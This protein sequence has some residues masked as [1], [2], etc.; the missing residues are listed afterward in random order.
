V[1]DTFRAKEPRTALE[2][3][4]AAQRNELKTH[5][6]YG[7]YNVQG[8]ARR[9]KIGRPAE[10][11]KDIYPAEV[12]FVRR[13][14]AKLD[15]HVTAV[16]NVGYRVDRVCP[17]SP[18]YGVLAENEVIRRVNRVSTLLNSTAAAHHLA[19][20]EKLVF[21]VIAMPKAEEHKKDMS[22]FVPAAQRMGLV[23][24]PTKPAPVD[25]QVQYQSPNSQYKSPQAEFILS[26]AF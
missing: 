16:N 21:E 9:K 1:V 7:E 10:S 8:K 13:K 11:E 23:Y 26:K 14:D 5:K 15:F 3:R 18:F 6:E 25:Y 12:K 20:M 22:R 2:T 4:I 19:T 17:G 24:T